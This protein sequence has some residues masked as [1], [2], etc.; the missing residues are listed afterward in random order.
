MKEDDSKY[1]MKIRGKNYHFYFCTT[2]EE[3]SDIR[4]EMLSLGIGLE[5]TDDFIADIFR[6]AQRDYVWEQT[7]KE[8]TKMLED[9]KKVK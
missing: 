9:K 5:K 2:R 6:V 3:L 4:K 7:D 8:I 1:K